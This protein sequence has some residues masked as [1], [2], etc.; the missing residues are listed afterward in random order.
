MGGRSGTTS[1]KGNPYAAYLEKY[2]IEDVVNGITV[3]RSKF[4]LRK[5][6]KKK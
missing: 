2:Q 1:K 5:R 4:R 6:K 3:I